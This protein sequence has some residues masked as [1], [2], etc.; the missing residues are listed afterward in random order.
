MTHFLR[1]IL[2]EN[3]LA[4]ISSVSNMALFLVVMKREERLNQM[5]VY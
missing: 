5:E 4:S 3:L 2:E 1:E